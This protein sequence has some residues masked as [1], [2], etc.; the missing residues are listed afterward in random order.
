MRWEDE[1]YV[2]FYTRDTAEF[3]AL[4]WVARGLFGLILR[5]ADRAGIL[6]VGKLGLKGVAVM[7]QAPWVEA[8]APLR[9]LVEDGCIS[10]DPT[11]GIV[12]IP[13]YLAAQEVSQS[14][15]AR[16]RASREKARSEAS[17]QLVLQP[18][19]AI[20]TER[21]P[22]ESQFVTDS[23]AGHEVGHTESQ[24]VT[25][26]S[27]VPCSAV[28]YSAVLK[29]KADDDSSPAAP[30]AVTAGPKIPL[31]QNGSG[32]TLGD[33]LAEQILVELQKHPSLANVATPRFAS[34]LAGR[35]QGKVR[36]WPWL[37]AAIEEVAVDSAASN[38]TDEALAQKVRRYIDNAKAPRDGPHGHP[39]PDDTGATQALKARVKARIAGAS[40]E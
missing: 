14:D 32:T 7:I 28:P 3:M 13:N 38:L 30:P 19:E 23:H 22:V 4:S 39:E 40:S 35:Q 18:Q 12:L 37:V 34:G 29:Q 17:A 15:K 24:P 36:P 2:R 1:Q 11:A 25:L 5:K 6:K 8:E 10:F 9:E 31:R 21:D 26:C 27:A 33:P 16:K 20:V